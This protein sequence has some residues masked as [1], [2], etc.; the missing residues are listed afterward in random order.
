MATGNF[1][2]AATIMLGCA[3][4]NGGAISMVAVPGV[5]PRFS[6]VKTARWS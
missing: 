2:P 1:C 3:I 5:P 4:W 6:T